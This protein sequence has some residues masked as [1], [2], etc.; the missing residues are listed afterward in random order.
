[1]AVTLDDINPITD[2]T[3]NPN[4][5]LTPEWAENTL[6]QQAI[7]TAWCG[8]A[9]DEINDQMVLGLGGG[10]RDYAG[11]E[12]YRANFFVESPAWLLV[13]PPS[14]AI[15]NLLTTND[16]Q[17]LTGLYSDNRPRATHGY[18]KWT[19]VPGVGPVM[20]AHGNTSWTAAGKTWGVFLDS[21]GE[22][23]FTSEPS[24]SGNESDGAGA[25]YDPS[26]HAIWVATRNN[27]PIHRY[28]IPSTGAPNLGT[29]STVGTGFDKYGCNSLVY[30]PGDDVLVLCSSDDN[31]T[32]QQMWVI[33][34]ATGQRYTP[35]ITGSGALLANSFGEVQ[36]R[37]VGR[38][39]HA[40]N[41]S[42]NRT[43]I[44]RLTPGVDAKND[45]WA[46]DTM[47]VDGGNTVTPSTRADNGTFGRFAYSPRL[48]GFLLFNST[49]GP[50]YFYKI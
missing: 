20:M 16:G 1:M 22:A 4:F 42:A 14:G 17:E 48:G 43:L 33:D 8:A 24:I 32:V 26:R 30:M 41:N 25:C 36:W 35:S 47:P 11:N 37:R 9:Y 39:L 27:D 45:A 5:P 21:L 50:T 44:T 7:V 40:W 31:R 18:N 29:Y 15:G 10:H 23:T 46:M 12:I 34:C 13:R 19:W 3:L 49:V 2:D 28:A 38:A 6:R